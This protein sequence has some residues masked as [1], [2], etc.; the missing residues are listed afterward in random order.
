MLQVVLMVSSAVATSNLLALVLVLA[1]GV[2]QLAY[3][4][5]IMAR[6]VHLAPCPAGEYSRVRF[7]LLLQMYDV[8]SL[9]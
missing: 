2:S 7:W 9:S 4:Q 3:G 5:Q 1:L 6:T 8:E